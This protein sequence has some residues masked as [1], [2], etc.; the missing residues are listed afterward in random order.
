[1]LL[2]LGFAACKPND[3][4]AKKTE[5]QANTY[6]QPSTHS[7]S[8]KFYDLN[9]PYIIKLPMELNE[10]SGVAYYPKDTSV[11][12]IQDEDG[13]LYK[14]PVKNPEAIRQWVFGNPK[15]YEDLLLKDNVFY[16]LVST[17]EIQR[18]KFKGPNV[19]VDRFSFLTEDKSKNEF[20]SIVLDSTG[21]ISIFCKKCE[22][23][24]DRQIS[25]YNFA[26]SSS[27]F[28]AD[29]AL[30][31][32]AAASELKIKSDGIRA[33]AAALNPVTKE[34]FVVSALSGKIFVFDR[35]RQFSRAYSLDPSI[36][37]Q[38]EGIAFTPEADLII[39]N[40]KGEAKSA[41]ILI[42]KNK[43]K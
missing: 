20:E 33:S 18:L 32:S 21:N 30:D 1:M 36:F 23:D 13:L 2:A 8:D 3:K 40:E 9:N 11:F 4:K 26:D 7:T 38:P 25:V 19:D 10:I 28:V 41:T 35:N 5:Y 6:S 17:G 12:A 37:N 31:I 14:I 16:V 22:G 27:S 43:L 24:E 29:S 15:D 42:F 39:S 34:L